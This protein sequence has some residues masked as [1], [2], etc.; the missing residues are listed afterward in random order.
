MERELAMEL[1]ALELLASMATT[2][3]SSKGKV[4]ILQRAAKY[5]PT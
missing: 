5:L 2:K 1:N 4:S 3:G